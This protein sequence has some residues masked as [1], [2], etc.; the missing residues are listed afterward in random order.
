MYSS[1]QVDIISGNAY[2]VVYRQRISTTSIKSAPAATIA[3]AAE[4]SAT[5]AAPGADASQSAAAAIEAKSDSSEAS[6]AQLAAKLAAEDAGDVQ[7]QL[8][9]QLLQQLQ[10][11]PHAVHQQVLDQHKEFEDACRCHQ[12]VQQDA[13]ARISHRQEVRYV[14]ADRLAVLLCPLHGARWC[15]ECL[16]IM[17]DHLLLV[18]RS[19]LSYD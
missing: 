7:V 14:A 3:A 11:L 13:L 6:D 4:T 1:L 2:F 19:M 9:P 15:D 5:E 18:S 8:H 17:L 10:Q 16:L 12:Q